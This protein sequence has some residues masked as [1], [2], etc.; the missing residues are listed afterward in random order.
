MGL[1]CD[2]GICIIQPCTEAPSLPSPTDRS[3]AP[4]L[5]FPKLAGSESTNQSPVSGKGMNGYIKLRCGPARLQ[6]VVCELVH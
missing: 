1:V 2:I 4:G 3:L 6:I 5:E